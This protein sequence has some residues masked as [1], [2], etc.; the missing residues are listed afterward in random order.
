MKRITFLGDL[1]NALRGNLTPMRDR[2]S[3][4]HWKYKWDIRYAMEEAGVTKADVG[5]SR[6]LVI[7]TP[8]KIHFF[9]RVHRPGILIG[10]KG[11]TLD[12][13]EQKLK[14]L[15]KPVVFHLRQFDPYWD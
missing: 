14:Y 7:P 3:F 9:I 4:N 13:I 10:R 12:A 6:I 15:G 2:L 11:A 1:A 8:R 5:I